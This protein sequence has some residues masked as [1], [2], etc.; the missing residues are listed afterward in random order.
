MGGAGQR[1]RPG[2]QDPAPSIPLRWASPVADNALGRARTCWVSH[3]GLVRAGSQ[4]AVPPPRLTGTAVTSVTSLSLSFPSQ[5]G[6]VLRLLLAQPPASRPAQ[7]TD[8]QA[9]AWTGLVCWCRVGWALTV[10]LPRGSQEGACSTDFL[11]SHP[12]GSWQDTSWLPAS[13]LTC[14]RVTPGT[15]PDA[16]THPRGPSAF[17]ALASCDAGS[18]GTGRVLA[19]GREEYSAQL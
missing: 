10:N 13:P 6:F 11:P 19:G 14:L 12:Q 2:G 16:V 5:R 4:D 9:D 15:G 17:L 3:R 18:M 7:W 1:E 8:G